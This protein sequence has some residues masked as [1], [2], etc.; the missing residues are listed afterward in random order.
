MLSHICIESEVIIFT[1]FSR[2]CEM[3]YFATCKVHKTMTSWVFEYA[4]YGGD[5]WIKERSVVFMKSGLRQLTPET[6]CPGLQYT[7]FGMVA[8]WLGDTGSGATGRLA[9]RFG[10]DG[11]KYT[12][13][14]T[15]HAISPAS[16]NQFTPNLGWWPGGWGTQGSGGTG[17][18]AGR[19]GRKCSF[20]E[21]WH[22]ISPASLNRFCLWRFS[23]SFDN[24]SCF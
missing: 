11:R 14:K 9:G 21:I 10:R 8:G 18:W 16:L 23:F 1:R 22:A 4:D 5:V 13:W 12:F 17:R 24:L 20:P 2:T 15:W 6:T 19:D 3:T 7:K